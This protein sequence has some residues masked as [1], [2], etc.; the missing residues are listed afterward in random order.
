MAFGSASA[1][2]WPVPPDWAGGVQE[3]LAW[4]TEVLQASGTAVTHHRSY[5]ATPR[6][7]FSFDVG[8]NAQRHR[9]VEMLIGGHRGTWELPIWPDGQRLAAPLSAD[10]DLIP[11]STEWLDF[12][13]GGRA[14]LLGS[15]NQWEVVE[16]ATVGDGYLVLEAPVQAAWPRGTRLYPLRR[17]WLQDG[18]EARLRT[19]SFSRRR[20]AFDLDEPCD[21]PELAG[22]A[23]HLGHRVLDR[24]P[25]S[26]A[27]PTFSVSGLRQSVDYGTGLPFHADLPRAALRAQRDTWSMVGREQRAWFR[28]LLY[29]LRGRQRPIWVPSWSTD[30][31]AV[32]A[33]SGTDLTVEWAGYS[34]FGAG[35]PNR[36]DLRIE[37]RNGAVHY[38]RVV[39]AVEAGQAETLTLSA[40]LDGASIEPRQIRKISMMALATL[41]SDSTEI[42]HKVDSQGVA[43]AVTGW[44]E[45][46]IDG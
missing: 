21:W 22:G 23:E 18:A 32:A 4:A 44:Q 5:R 10:T 16:V 25:R 45:V 38:R 28:S 40:P 11:C 43:Q 37:L 17:A 20:L 30:L 12:S 33:V 39:D 6:R 15:I 29:T 3:S 27:E 42:D 7:G 8:A 35:R 34:L 26:S 19:D 9:V 41:A 14:L 31:Q 46:L 13:E 24:R 1:R 36:R 2:I